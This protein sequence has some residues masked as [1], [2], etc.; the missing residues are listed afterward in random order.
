VPGTRRPHSTRSCS[1]R[2]SIL[3]PTRIGTVELRWKSAE[4]GITERSTT[5]IVA[6][7]TESE[8]EPSLRL[9]AAVADLAQV[10]KGSTPLVD[11]GVTFDD[12]AV[13]AADLD[14]GGV[15]GAELVRILDQVRQAE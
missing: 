14:A 3:L 4:S 8:S 7:D 11:S 13:T 2:R 10:L 6:A 9:A 12:I 15:D 5:P 1:T